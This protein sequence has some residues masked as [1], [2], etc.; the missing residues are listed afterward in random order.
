MTLTSLP[1]SCTIVLASYNGAAFLAEQL[2][3]FAAQEGVDWR[4]L[5]SDDG[6][7]DATPAILA[8]YQTA[9]PQGR[10]SQI[11]GPKRGIVANFL[12]LLKHL[13]PETQYAALSDQD[14]VWFKDK[15]ARATHALARL[16]AGQPA[17][18][19]AATRICAE[20]LT[21]VGPSAHFTK[22]PHFR[23]ALVQ[24]IGGG[25]T[26]VM[27]AAALALTQAA[28][29][30]IETAGA[31]LPAMHDWWLYQL[32]SGAG[33]VILRDPEPVLDYRQHGGNAIGANTG[34]TAQLHRWAMIMGRRYAGWNQQ[35]LSALGASGARLTPEAQSVLS[36][37]ATACRA[38]L[39]ARLA[40]LRRSGV[41]R[42]SGVGTAALYLACL[43]GRI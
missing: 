41:Y 2:D 39:P 27:N 15:L 35:N 1:P 7:K 6:S 11:P 21:P 9:W 10:L 12:H 14:D 43:L 3:S 24:S 42:Q 25:N 31:D 28:I 37:Y 40:A 34:F 29:Q 13:P 17:L 18:Y 19:C 38:P 20:D 23:N 4:V 33:G 22:P 32:I 30:D 5:V 16:P 26:M 8:R 36:E